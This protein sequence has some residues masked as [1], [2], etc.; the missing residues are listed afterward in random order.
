MYRGIK[1]WVVVM[2]ITILLTVAAVNFAMGF[3]M[4]AFFGY[5][6]SRLQWIV[7]WV[8]DPPFAPPRV[9]NSFTRSIQA[10]LAARKASAQQSAEPADEQTAPEEL[11]ASQE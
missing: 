4:A 8:D 1:A 3:I 2:N 6:P 11:P 9:F 7:H 10:R 5:G